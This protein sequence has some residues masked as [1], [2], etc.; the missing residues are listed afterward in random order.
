MP[1]GSQSVFV[2][3]LT[4]VFKRISK[5]QVADNPSINKRSLK[6]GNIDSDFGK[7]KYWAP[8]GVDPL[9]R[10]CGDI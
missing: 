3:V 7:S 10:I 6:R 4:G 2:K 1:S 5:C 9:S 8:L